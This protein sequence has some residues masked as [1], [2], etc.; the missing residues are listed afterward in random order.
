MNLADKILLIGGLILVVLLY[1]AAAY[2]I[3]QQVGRKRSIGFRN[4]FIISLINPMVGLF[5]SLSSR[6]RKR[7]IFLEKKLME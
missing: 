1:V 4:S 3:A 2:T 5:I 7:T 6:K